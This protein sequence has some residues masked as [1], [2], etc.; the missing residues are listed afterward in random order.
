MTTPLHTPRPLLHHA[1]EVSLNASVNTSLPLNYS[2]QE[3]ELFNAAKQRELRRNQLL[4]TIKGDAKKLRGIIKV[5]KLVR[6]ARVRTLMFRKHGF[7]C[8]V[9][10]SKCQN[11]YNPYVLD[12]KR[13][14]PPFKYEQ[15]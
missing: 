9:S 5:Q 2:M 6:G 15:T 3:L 8:A 1:S 12:I 4:S 11:Y 10:K 7:Q 14:L 13:R